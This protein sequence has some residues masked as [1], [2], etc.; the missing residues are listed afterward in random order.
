MKITH[1]H[2]VGVES[3]Q[4]TVKIKFRP[5]GSDSADDPISI[6]VSP[7]ASYLF[8]NLNSAEFDNGGNTASLKISPIT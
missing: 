6:S 8:L 2:I 7:H 4:N 3:D 1:T 5:Q